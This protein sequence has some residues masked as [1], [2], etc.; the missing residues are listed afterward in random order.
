MSNYIMIRIMNRECSHMRVSHQKQSRRLYLIV[1]SYN[2]KM[3]SHF[4]EESTSLKNMTISLN[5][6]LSALLNLLF[7]IEKISAYD[8]PF[9]V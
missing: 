8:L 2:K 3:L 1:N 5:Y 7:S 4:R 9:F 6:F